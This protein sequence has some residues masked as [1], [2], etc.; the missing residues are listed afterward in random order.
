MTTWFKRDEFLDIAKAIEASTNITDLLIGTAERAGVTM[1]AYMH[2]PAIGSL[3]FGNN[4][5]FHS[6]HIPE[7]VAE[8]YRNLKKPDVIIR[9]GLESGKSVWL[10]DT[11]NYPNVAGTPDEIR[12]RATLEGTGDGICCP[13]YGPENRRGFAFT[14]IGKDKSK[15]SP[16]AFYQFQALLQ[17]M[18]LQ[19]CQLVKGIQ[20]KIKLTPRE[21]EVLE[22][23][24]YGKTNTE[25]GKI[26]D[27]SPRT[28]DGHTRNI[29]LKLGTSDRVSTALRAQTID[30]SP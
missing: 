2:F 13:L 22:L 7:P 5:L 20:D 21:S 19:Y 17:N 8:Y 3:D 23:I 26:L 28:A 6:Y 1:S 30:L 10:S 27:I 11:L 29:Y 14:A 15:V 24:C 9:N 16:L 12:I 18:H 4:G 25:I